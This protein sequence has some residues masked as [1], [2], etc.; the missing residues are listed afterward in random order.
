MNFLTLS[1]ISKSYGERVLFADL[2]M[3]INEG[4]KV[5]LIAK[6]G[7]G[8][9]SLLNIITGL[10]SPDIDKGSVFLHKDSQMA[11]LSQEAN[12][13]EKL[14]VFDAVYTSP[15]PVMKAIA[16]YE[17]SMLHEDVDAMQDAISE[18]DRLS[19]WDFEA[20]VKEILT[21]LQVD[22]FDKPIGQLSGGQKKRVALAKTL[23]DA[24]R[25]LILDEPTNH[26]DLHMIEWLEEYMKQPNITLLM[27]THDRFFLEAVCNNI[28]ELDNGEL[29]KY[30]G[31]YSEYLMKKAERDENSAVQSAKNQN[32]FR[33]ELDWMRR[34]PQ[35]RTTKAKSRI[36]A[37]FELDKKVKNKVNNDVMTIDIQM[38]R[39]GSKIVELHNV[40]ISFGNQVILKN[41][42]YKFKP[43]DR[44]GLVGRNG[45]GKSTLLNLITEGLQPD[46]GKVVV[47]DTVVIGYYSQHTPDFSNEKRVIDIIKDIA[48][49]IPL[50]GGKKLG[51]AQLLEQFLF[52]PRNQQ[53][54]VSKL[55]GG[56]KRR[57]HL[58]TLLIKNPNFL[59][60]DEP[61]NDLD[62]MTLQVLEEF[63]ETYEGILLIVSHD[64]HFMDKLVEHTFALEGNGY[65]RDFPGNYSAYREFKNQE[66]AQSRKDAAQEKKGQPI[67]VVQ[68]VNVN[69]KELK[70]IEKELERLEKQKSDLT[71]KFNDVNL[72]QD[73]MLKYSTDLK[74]VISKIEESEAKWLDLVG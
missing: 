35:A 46:S 6:N 14:T 44:I 8:K 53:T 42:D 4:D 16:A 21:K 26:L 65:V 23:I 9:T 54:M 47:G 33:K 24:P 52:E 68:Q 72:S 7:T 55:S 2:T 38:N 37:F 56:E 34:Q 43:K 67:A 30:T 15:S 19:G 48:E 74:D 57:L 29:V 50:K 63:L 22:F 32:L 60:L 10:E 69:E 36:D 1:N 11:F 66:L 45:M 18:M 61:T 39:L 64:R 27:V 71:A 70:R 59:I 31:N 41:F 25:F 40:G 12:L 51:A 13:D 20:K 73:L 58:L 17:K 28:I 3:H 49:Y 5:A 62:V